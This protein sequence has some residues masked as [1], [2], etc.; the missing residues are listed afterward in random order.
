VATDTSV[1][2]AL[3]LGA[4]LTDPA[5]SIRRAVDL[6]A[7]GGV[8]GV[9]LSSLYA[10][11]PVGCVAGTPAFINACITGFWLG[12]PGALLS[13]CQRIERTLGRPARHSS[14][15]A[16][17]IDIDILLF[18]DRVVSDRTLHIPH[19]RLHERLFVLTPLADLAGDWRVPPGGVTVGELRERLLRRHPELAATVVPVR[20]PD[21]AGG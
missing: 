5:T 8:T 20:S 7:T 11:E 12:A 14:R 15:E 19:R 4:N 13:L 16:R 3:G 6:L 18:G 9:H 1:A 21:A 17:S 2:T 10:T